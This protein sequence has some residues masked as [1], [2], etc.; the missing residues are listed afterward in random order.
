MIV[1]PL[2]KARFMFLSYASEDKRHA[3]VLIRG[4][5]EHAI[6]TWAALK[7]IRPGEIWD[8]G[9]EEAVQTCSGVLVLASE[10]SINSSYVRAEVEHAIKAGKSVTPICIDT[11]DLPL[12]WS[13]YQC[14][15]SGH[16][17]G[18]R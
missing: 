14:I 17:S 16:T 9:I 18:R 11:A 13:M 5:H 3:E 4:L 6:D 7:D 15:G 8:R 12:R 2:G 1:T 10:R